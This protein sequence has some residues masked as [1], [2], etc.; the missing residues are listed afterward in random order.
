MNIL[1]RRSFLKRSASAVGMAM[2]SLLSVPGFLRSAIADEHGISWNGNKIMFLFLRGGNDG[3]NT[4]IPT[5]DG[6]YNNV[7]R[8]TLYIPSPTDPLTTIGQCPTD[9]EPGRGIDLGNGFA[10][11]HPALS[12]LCSL[13]NDGE[14]AMIHRVGYPNQSRS[15]FDSERYW[16]TGVPLDDSLTEGIFYR[17]L[18]ETGL[19]K[20]QVLPGVSL[21]STM[22]T[23]LRGDIAMANISDPHRYDLLGVY[24]AARQK[25]I[26]SIARIHGLNY[27][28]KSSRD[29]VFPTGERFVTSINQ[30]AAVDFH[31]NGLDESENKI[32][33][34]PFL[35]DDVDNTHLFPVNHETDDKGFDDYGAFNLFRSIK[36]SAQIL[37]RTDAVV[38]GTEMHGYDTHNEQGGEQGGVDGWHADLLRRVGWTLYALK[39]YMSHPSVDIWDKTVVVTLT[40]FGRTTV[41]NESAGTDHAEAGVMFLSGGPVAGGVYHCDGNAASLP[42]IPGDTGSMF[43]TNDRYLSRA[44]DYRSILGELARDH[45]GAT[46]EQ[47]A[48]II[49]G[50]ANPGENLQS[51]GLSIDGVPISGELGILLS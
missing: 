15:H 18:V 30:I 50:Y 36:Y 17:T 34:S 48:R 26:D 42:W 6:A 41:E 12:D 9:P 28:R 7:T 51:G 2:G 3:L 20:S 22:P 33:G 45:L 4:I 44:V 46:P 43:E 13:Y 14:L 16:E 31:D 29:T 21:Q 37:A 1:T 19:H 11:M 32:P 24:A 38:A 5:G 8:P 23:I 35:D 47:L 40:E 27:P 39:K 49:P 25:H 10:T